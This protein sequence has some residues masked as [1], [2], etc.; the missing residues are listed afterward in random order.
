M[1]QRYQNLLSIRAC[2][3]KLNRKKNLCLTG[4]SLTYYIIANR[5]SLPSSLPTFVCKIEEKNFRNKNFITQ[6]RIYL[7]K[8][9]DSGI[10]IISISSTVQETS[11]VIGR[12]I[13]VLT[14]LRQYHAYVRNK[15]AFTHGLDWIFGGLTNRKRNEKRILSILG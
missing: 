4:F 2:L 7:D 11:K 12:S 3:K 6:T 15:I 13:F 8:L 9:R 1:K 10:R 14:L 5:A